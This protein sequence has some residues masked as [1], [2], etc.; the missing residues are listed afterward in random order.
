MTRKLY[1]EA[2][3]I[4]QWL[5]NGHMMWR[6]NGCKAPACRAVDSFTDDY[7][8]SQSTIDLW[9]AENCAVIEDDRR[10]GSAWNKSSELYANYVKWKKDRNE[11]PQPSSRFGE[12]MSSRFAKVSSNGVRYV[13]LLLK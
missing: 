13:G 10:A 5:I 11:T 2:G 4:I 12:F 3:F 6:E 1:Q 8:H 7:F 9:L